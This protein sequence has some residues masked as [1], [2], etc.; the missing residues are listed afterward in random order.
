MTD[1]I[2]KIRHFDYSED[3]E[4]INSFRSGSRSEEWEKS[5]ADGIQSALRRNNPISGLKELLGFHV[6]TQ[7][8]QQ[9]E[10]QK[11]LSSI[12]TLL[13]INIGLLVIIIYLIF[14]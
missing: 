11:L 2:E 5:L 1:E 14:K 12:R 3:E 8:H 13:F 10:Q 7:A 4:I 9:R 6:V